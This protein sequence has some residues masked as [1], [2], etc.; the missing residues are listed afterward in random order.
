MLKIRKTTLLLLTIFFCGTAAY[1]QTGDKVS[2]KEVEQFVAAVKEVQVIN[3]ESQ[4]SMISAVQE[5]GLDIQ[6]FNQ[7]YGAMQDP[8][9]DVEASDEEMEKFNKANTEIVSI[10]TEAQQEMEKK[11]LEQDLTIERYQEINMQV[12]DD[13]ELMKKVQTLLQEEG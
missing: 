1:A 8:N 2:D 12:Q 10:Q 4:Q 3:Q 13:P 11:I 6:R 5:S 7:I 9:T